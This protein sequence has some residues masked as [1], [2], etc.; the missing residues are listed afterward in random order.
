MV[1][2]DSRQDMAR[3]TSVSNTVVRIRLAAEGM[4][5]EETEHMSVASEYSAFA[6]RG[7]RIEQARV[8]IQE[9]L[10]KASTDG[11]SR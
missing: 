8:A 1:I 9:S 11:L 10:K 3:K 6:D 7:M 5:P 4:F 2:D